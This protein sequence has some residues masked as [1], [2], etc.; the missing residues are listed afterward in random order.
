MAL[1]KILDQGI[2]VVIELGY[3]T[4]GYY[5]DCTGASL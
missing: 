1:S 2:Y 3:F 5:A 4:K